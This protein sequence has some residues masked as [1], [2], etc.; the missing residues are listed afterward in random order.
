MTGGMPADGLMIVAAPRYHDP[1]RP[2]AERI[3]DAFQLTRLSLAFGAV[4][5]LERLAGGANGSRRA[6]ARGLGGGLALAGV[7]AIGTVGLVYDTLPESISRPFAQFSIPMIRAVR[8]IVHEG[9]TVAQA[10]QAYEDYKSD[11][12]KAG[13]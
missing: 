2:V 8:G 1:V 10:Y 5:A 9:H 4:C 13:A 11:A 3:L 6:M 7:L 12:A